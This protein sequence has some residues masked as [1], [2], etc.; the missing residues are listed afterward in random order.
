MTHEKLNTIIEGCM[1]DTP[2][3]LLYAG[4]ELQI[5]ENLQIVFCENG[6]HE[7]RY[8]L[9]ARSSDFVDF[10]VINNPFYESYKESKQALKGGWP[11]KRI[12]PNFNWIFDAQRSIT[13]KDGRIYIDAMYFAKSWRWYLDAVPTI[14]RECGEVFSGEKCIDDF[15]EKPSR[16]W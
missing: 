4:I 13:T 2:R 1:P 3:S 11:I 7:D 16:S 10:E 5:P 15:Y 6:V 8:L 9:Y 12:E 14:L